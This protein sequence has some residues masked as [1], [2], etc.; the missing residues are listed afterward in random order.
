MEDEIKA[1]W[2]AICDPQSTSG[3]IWDAWTRLRELL[4]EAANGG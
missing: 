4:Q 3:E 1:L 2:S